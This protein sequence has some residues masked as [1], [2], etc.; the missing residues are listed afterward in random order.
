MVV[1]SSQE[2]GGHAG[3]VQSEQAVTVNVVDG[4]VADDVFAALYGEAQ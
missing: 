2:R 4:W 1:G 3:L